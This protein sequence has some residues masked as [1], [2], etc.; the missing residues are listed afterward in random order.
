M[1]RLTIIL[2]IILVILLAVL[3][4]LYFMG[5]RLQSRQE[6]SEE[7]IQASKQPMTLLV[8]DKKRLKLKESGLPD[9]IIQQTPWYAKRSK[10]PVVKAKVGPQFIN[11]ICDEKIFDS[12]PVKKQVKA[13]VSGIYIVEVKGIRGKLPT[14]GEPK[15]KSWIEKLQE[16][17][18]ARPVK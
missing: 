7:Q 12:I 15:K 3:I 18:G 17:A 4:V 8:I 5:K 10:V 16:K 2:L 13:M 9:Q 1:S 11:F 6:E 14:D